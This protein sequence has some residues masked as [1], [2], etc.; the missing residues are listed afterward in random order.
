MEQMIEPGIARRGGRPSRRDAQE[1]LKRVL[2]IAQRHFL[3]VGYKETTLEGVARAAGVAKKTLYHHFNGK[4]D[5]FAH[6][7]ERL[8]RNWIAELSDIV[9]SSGKPVHVLNAVALRLLEVGTTPEKIKMHRL[10]LLE[11]DR[12]PKAVRVIYDKRGALLGMKPL[13]NYLI[14]AVAAGEL[15]IDDV[16]LA[17]EQFVHLVR[18]GIRERLL[19]GITKRPSVS[20][21]RRMAKQA[22][23]IFLAGV[24]SS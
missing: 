22:V 17:T 20:E 5:L 19:L 8:L 14:S 9:L 6:I 1:R 4:S 15:E 16:D 7:L 18:G 13:F 2:D 10:L 11:A 3:K 21:R 12:F 24:R 23:T